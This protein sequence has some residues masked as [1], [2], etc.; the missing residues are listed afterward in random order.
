MKS[1]FFPFICSLGYDQTKFNNKGK[2]EG[3]EEKPKKKKQKEREEQKRRKKTS[4]ET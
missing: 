3:D 4:E 1:A 2:S